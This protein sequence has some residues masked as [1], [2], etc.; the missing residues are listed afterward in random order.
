MV[1]TTFVF[2]DA[3]TATAASDM[4]ATMNALFILIFLTFLILFS[5]PEKTVDLDFATLSG[6][7]EKAWLARG[8]RIKFGMAP[9]IGCPPKNLTEPFCFRSS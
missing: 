9:E 1:V 2:A 4:S 6:F 3:G 5:L 7:R 8:F